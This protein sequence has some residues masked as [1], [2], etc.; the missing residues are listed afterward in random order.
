M[1]QTVDEQLRV[2]MALQGFPLQA[3][4]EKA[5]PPTTARKT[6][7]WASDVPK[8]SELVA[9]QAPSPEKKEKR[10]GSLPAVVPTRMVTRAA[11][12]AAEAETQR[13][14]GKASHEGNASTN[15][16]SPKVATDRVQKPHSMAKTSRQTGNR[17]SPELVTESTT[18]VTRAMAGRV[19]NAEAH[20]DSANEPRAHKAVTAEKAV[21]KRARTTTPAKTIN[22]RK[23]HKARSPMKTGKSGPKE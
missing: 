1:P 21:S 8:T 5:P 12:A 10:K 15:S 20:T 22:T 3:L 16:K 9:K 17:K 23:V 11:A 7:T 2:Y 18:V 4:E 19:S 14:V 6:V 13:E